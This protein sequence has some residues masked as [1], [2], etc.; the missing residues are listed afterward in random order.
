MV[1]AALTGDVDES[2][3][4]NAIKTL[5]RLGEPAG[6]IP[7]AM[8]P[9]CQLLLRNLNI[10]CNMLC[11]KALRS[12]GVDAVK[13]S[14]P[15]LLSFVLTANVDDTS[16]TEALYTLA[17]LPSDYASEE[18]VAIPGHGQMQTLLGILL[19]VEQG[20]WSSEVRKSASMLRSSIV[21]ELDV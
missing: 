20:Q 13:T 10:R 4:E 8:Q 12:F 18:S 15:N 5:T 17:C 11:L 2:I 19:E 6:L 3:L 21:A 9:L 7:I 14:L 16:R 1:C